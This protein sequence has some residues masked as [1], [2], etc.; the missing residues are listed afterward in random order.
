MG[1]RTVA[2]TDTAYEALAREKRSGE[3][4]TDAV[5]RLTG[6]PSLAALADVMTARESA[7]LAEA[8]L[9]ARRRRAP[10]KE[11]PL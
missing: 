6:A 7:S 10:R 9:E 3:S 11:G 5:L 1:S 2:I 8:H 4:F